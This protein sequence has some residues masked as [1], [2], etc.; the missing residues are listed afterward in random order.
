MSNHREVTVT[1]ESTDR[2]QRGP[3]ARSRRLVL[4][5]AA[6]L[7]MCISGVGEPAAFAQPRPNIIFVLTDDHGIDAMEGPGWPN[8]LEVHTPRLASLASRGRVFPWARTNPVCS[9]T[10]AGILTG[11]T[12]YSTG[13]TNVISDSSLHPDMHKVALQNHEWTIAEALRERGYYT[14]LIDKWHV[15][16]DL[17]QYGQTAL[18]QGF[19]RVVPGARFFHLDDPI[20]VGD[21]HLSR[22]ID[23]AVEA[24]RDRPNPSS[25]YALFLWSSDP[26]DRNDPSGREPYEWWR[27][28]PSLLP[29]GENYYG[30]EVD[31]NRN[32]YR[33]VI[34]ALD[35]EVDRLLRTLGVVDEE[36]RYRDESNT[37][38]IFMGDNGTPRKVAAIA[39]RAKP[40][41]YEGGT[42]VP[43]FV[44]GEKVP[45][46][47]R[48]MDRLVSHM[49]LYETIADIAGIE[50]EDRGVFARQSLSLADE[51]GWSTAP[52]P[53]REFTVSSLGGPLPKD[54]LVALSDRRYKLIV[55]AG[56]ATPDPYDRGLFYDLE[57]DPEERENLLLGELTQVQFERFIAMREALPDYWPGAVPAPSTAVVYLSPSDLMSLATD[58]T[59]IRGL[60]PVGHEEPNTGDWKEWRGFIRWD[61]N[62]LVNNLPPGIGMENLRSAQIVLVFAGD[63]RSPRNS[64]TGLITAYACTEN[65]YDTQNPKWRNLKDAHDFSRPVG[66]VD[67]PTY[68]LPD[69]SGDLVGHPLPIGAMVSLGRSE[70]LYDLVNDWVDRPSANH[71]VVLRSVPVADLEGDQ[72]VG[73]LPE[74]YLRLTFWK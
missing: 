62:S 10:R 53:D 68:I 70:V 48:Q 51:I 49:D 71:G 13:V 1:P 33:A 60:Y 37:V 29:S 14:I 30:P 50:V 63:T 67:F 31:S 34:E 18:D 36:R 55:A 54:H 24:V 52:L 69:P 56:S 21:E 27:V 32:R 15:G 25:P 65:W 12:A 4:L 59:V 11:R 20:E 44:F 23:F 41:L 57:A 73:L 64:D 22:M 66:S 6:A 9:A 7:M 61:L 72:R 45:T 38:F 16:T 2:L 5:I 28:S 19:D 40:S 58:S 47:G 3:G 17:D 42:R 43:L 46:D 26:H 8:E 39:D 74:A 35:T